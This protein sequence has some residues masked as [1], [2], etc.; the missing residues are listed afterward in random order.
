MEIA[1]ILTRALLPFLNPLAAQHCVGGT[2]YDC[3]NGETHSHSSS[4]SV[5]RCTTVTTA[6]RIYT[7]PVRRWQ[8]YDCDNGDKHS[9]SI[10][11]LHRC[12]KTAFTQH[13][14]IASVME[15]SPET[16]SHTI[17]AL[18]RCWKN[19][20]K[21]IH[22]TSMHCVCVGKIVR[23]SIHTASKH[24]VGVGKFA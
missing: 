11:T 21:R 10:Y 14:F 2:V 3:D 6:K 16:H 12:C 9:H 15:K 5:A 24:C 23:K 13:L 1:E 18:R 17:Y 22:T 19:R 8:G 7:K 4:A 20:L